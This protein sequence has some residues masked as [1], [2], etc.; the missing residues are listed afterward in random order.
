M[1]MTKEATQTELF[2]ITTITEGY[3]NPLN[4]FKMMRSSL[5]FSKKDLWLAVVIKA[6]EHT[7]N[8]RD[9]ASILVQDGLVECNELVLKAAA[10]QYIQV[11]SLKNSYDQSLSSINEMLTHFEGKLVA[12]NPVVDSILNYCET[13][14]SNASSKDMEELMEYLKTAKLAKYLD[15]F[16]KFQVTA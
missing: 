13:I 12:Q 10:L 4:S 3:T 8:Y 14:F 1:T 7:A 5:D 15:F 16:Q 2:I 11:K 6:L 9:M